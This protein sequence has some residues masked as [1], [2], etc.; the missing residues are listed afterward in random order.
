MM[1]GA[2]PTKQGPTTAAEPAGTADA[3]LLIRAMIAAANADGVIDKAERDAILGQLQLADLSTEEH[4]FITNELLAPANLE[5]I[6]NRVDSAA[7]ARQVYTVSLM[8]IEVDTDAE[9]S[10]MQ[11]LAGR[12]GLDEATVVQIKRSLEMD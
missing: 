3:V 12:L 4:A 10:Y 8:A 11:N 2:Q 9:R 6:V 5:A 1:P 7:L